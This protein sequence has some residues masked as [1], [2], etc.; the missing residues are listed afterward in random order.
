MSRRSRPKQTRK[1]FAAANAPGSSR[2]PGAAPNVPTVRGARSRR[3]DSRNASRQALPRESGSR[4]PSVGDATARQKRNARTSRVG[5]APVAAGYEAARP[6]SDVA[7]VFA[8]SFPQTTLAAQTA[9]TR[10][11]LRT[12]A[13]QEYL[14]NPRAAGIA[15]LFGLYVVGTGPRLKFRGWDAYLKR[16]VDRDLA[17]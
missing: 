11:S 15:R 13:R 12:Q 16:P 1:R 5:A 7:S 10:S 17:R 3:R 4:L 8:R 6:N 14:N 9:P 2:Y